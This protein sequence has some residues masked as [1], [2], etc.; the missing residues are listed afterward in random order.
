MN[1]EDSTR[2]EKFRQIRKDIRGVMFI[3]EN[4]NT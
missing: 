4:S 3:A 1:E 2:L